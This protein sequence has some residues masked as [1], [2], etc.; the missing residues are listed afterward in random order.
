MRLIGCKGEG[1]L[2]SDACGDRRYE[3]QGRSSWAL[4]HAVGFVPWRA[5]RQEVRLGR[6]S[7]RHG[8]NGLIGDVVVCL[9]KGEVFFLVEVHEPQRVY[10]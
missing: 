4:W 5:S 2:I 7:Y 3:E 6:N 10:L 1:R 8:N 9:G